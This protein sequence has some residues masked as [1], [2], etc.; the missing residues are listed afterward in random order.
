M[1][2]DAPI[3][4]TKFTRGLTAKICLALVTIKTLDRCP[5]AIPSKLEHDHHTEGYT[6]RDKRQKE[7]R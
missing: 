7:P 5:W 2:A 4:S 1:E 3:L 6:G